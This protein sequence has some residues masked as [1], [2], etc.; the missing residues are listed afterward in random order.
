LGEKV[1]R[2]N[3]IEKNSVEKVSLRSSDDVAAMVRSPPL[4]VEVDMEFG[5]AVPLQMVT[6]PMLIWIRLALAP[7]ATAILVSVT[8]AVASL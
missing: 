4:K 6:P 7:Q 2:T 3:V 5:N 8:A 1:R